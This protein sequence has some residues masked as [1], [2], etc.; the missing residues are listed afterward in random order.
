MILTVLEKLLKA[1][2]LLAGAGA[3]AVIKDLLSS[4]L[5]TFV[6]CLKADIVKPASVR[7]AVVI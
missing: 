2:L 4:A 7:R 1:V 3:G 5:V 6:V